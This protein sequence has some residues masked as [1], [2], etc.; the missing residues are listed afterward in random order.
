L[1]HLRLEERLSKPSETAVNRDW[2][3]AS[4]KRM[5]SFCGLSVV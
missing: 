3:R 4:T 1:V 2:P 5:W